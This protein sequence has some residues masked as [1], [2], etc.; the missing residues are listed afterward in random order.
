MCALALGGWSAD[1]LQHQQFSEPVLYSPWLAHPKSYA[2]P[3]GPVCST[4]MVK[5]MVTSTA[6][7]A[8]AAL[9]VCTKTM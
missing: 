2:M 8:A 1:R 9:L 6:M 4:S 5:I 7:C 3:F